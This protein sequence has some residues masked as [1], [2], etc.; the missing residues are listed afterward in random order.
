METLLIRA[1]ETMLLLGAVLTLG[2]GL[3]A[4]VGYWAMRTP[5]RKRK[6]AK[7]RLHV[8]VD[9]HREICRAVMQ[10]RSERK[11]NRRLSETSKASHR[12]KR[13]C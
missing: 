5:T 1:T 4:L 10:D 13:G 12:L 8:D 11:A 6:L 7:D 3:G 2:A 9:L